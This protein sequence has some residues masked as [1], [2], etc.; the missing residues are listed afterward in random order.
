MNR[1]TS[2]KAPILRCEKLHK[3]F[4]GLRA[5]NNVGFEVE[6]GLKL[7]IIG[8]NGAGKTVLFNL[9]SGFLQVDAGVVRLRGSDVTGWRPHRIASAGLSRTFQLVGALPHMTVRDVLELA[10]V[11]P[12]GRTAAREHGGRDVYVETVAAQLGLSEH[13]DRETPDLN[14][15]VLRQVDIARA[16]MSSPRVLL[17]DEPFASLGHAEVDR[18]G[19]MIEK[20]NS[21]GLTVVIV[22]HKLRALMRLVDDVLVLN[23]GEV[24]ARGAPRDV[25]EDPD[26]AK[27]YL[28][29]RG[30]EVLE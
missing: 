28:G 27:A 7:G 11:G 14:L 18:V 17:L 13:L 25:I 4:G 8:P 29:S 15:G 3:A 10:T 1:R 22:E 5:V 6:E 20:V 23:F 2:R 12:R 24:I 26:V 9:I 21:E 16:I 19:R 30:K